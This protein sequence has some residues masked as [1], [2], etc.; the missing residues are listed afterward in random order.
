ME[1]KKETNTKIL[2]TTDLKG[3]SQFEN[4][5]VNTIAWKLNNKIMPSLF[6][7]SKLKAVNENEYNSIIKTFQ[8]QIFLK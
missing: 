2:D 1:L 4:E 7:M 5:I 6:E 3:V 8:R